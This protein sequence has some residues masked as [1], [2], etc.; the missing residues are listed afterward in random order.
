MANFVNI[1]GT[2]HGYWADVYGAQRGNYT[3]SIPGSNLYNSNDVVTWNFSDTMTLIYPTDVTSSKEYFI[4]FTT[5]NDGITRQY[6]FSNSFYLPSGYL[7]DGISEIFLFPPPFEIDRWNAGT[8]VNVHQ[9]AISKSWLSTPASYV[10][11]WTSSNP[12]PVIAPNT[13]IRV[14]LKVG[15]FRQSA[16]KSDTCPF[17]GSV[18]VTCLNP[19]RRKNQFLTVIDL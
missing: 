1:S 6:Q 5:P 9:F 3:I 17:N 19:T 18:V 16:Y 14:Q 4:Y 2:E 10:I 15:F 13:D 11:S 12:S 8:W 7:T